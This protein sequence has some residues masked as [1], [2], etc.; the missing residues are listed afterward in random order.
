MSEI[1]LTL[2]EVCGRIHLRKSWVYDAVQ[3]GDFPKPVHLTPRRVAWRES[4]VQA[5]MAERVA[6]SAAAPAWGTE[7]RKRRKNAVHG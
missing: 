4:D 5:W 3:R 6:A 2:P 1:F 7:N